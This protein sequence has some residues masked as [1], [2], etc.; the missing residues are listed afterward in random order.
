MNRLQKLRKLCCVNYF[1]EFLKDILRKRK[2]ENNGCEGRNCKNI[3]SV[4]R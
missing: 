1:K 2:I 4:N 3:I